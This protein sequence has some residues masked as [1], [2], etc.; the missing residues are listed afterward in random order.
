[1]IRL[2][3]A[4]KNFLDYLALERGLSR[5]TLE[6]YESDM[7]GFVSFLNAK[8]AGTAPESAAPADLKLYREHCLKSG[9]SDKTVARRISVLRSFYSYLES[10]CGAHGNPAAL[11]ASFKTADALPHTISEQNVN[12]LLLSIVEDG[13]LGLRDLALL[14]VL[15]SCGLR[16]SEAGALKLDDLRFEEGFL[17][18]TGKGFKTRIVPIGSCAGTALESYIKSGRPRLHPDPSEKHVFLNKNGRPFSRCGMWR[19]VKSR[20]A[21]AGLPPD[22]SPH[23]FRHSFATHM[24]EHGASI[25]IIQ[26]LL[27]HADIS[28][29]QIYTHVDSARLR[30]LHSKFHPRA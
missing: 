4:V 27:G 1:M 28:T 12:S 17:R 16:I 21:S 29:T 15:Y 11:L 30:E 24:L 10:E 6:A 25:R 26:E 18:C 2:R 7:S 20:V 8:S 22:V 14:E 3:N 19:A 9:L 5:K 13:P 23:W